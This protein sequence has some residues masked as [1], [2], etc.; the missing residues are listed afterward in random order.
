M[1][2]DYYLALPWHFL[3]EFLEREQEFLAR[4]GKFIVPLPV[5][6]LQFPDEHVVA[7]SAWPELASV[8]PPPH[9]HGQPEPSPLSFFNPFPDTVFPVT[10]APELISMKMPSSQ[11]P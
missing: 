8:I 3:D 9:N 10:T 5:M 6:P 4:G 11:F 7:T 1:N 2:P